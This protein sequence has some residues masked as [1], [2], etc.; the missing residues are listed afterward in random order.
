MSKPDGQQEP[1]PTPP[2]LVIKVVSTQGV[3][4]TRVPAT[5]A[6][7]GRVEQFAKDCAASASPV[8]QP[9]PEPRIRYL[10]DEGDWCELT[11]DTWLDAVQLAQDT[12][13]VLRVE[14]SAKPGT[15][16][17]RT[18]SAATTA[19][20][21]VST[22]P[23]TTSP[24]WASPGALPVVLPLKDTAPQGSISSHSATATV[25]PTA[26]GTE[27]RRSLA[28]SIATVD[29]QP[30][31]V[32][33]EAPSRVGSADPFPVWAPPGLQPQP[34]QQYNTPEERESNKNTTPTLGRGNEAAQSGM[35]YP[36]A[37][38]STRADLGPPPGFQ[39][40]RKSYAPKPI[41][42][43]YLALTECGRLTPRIMASV[44][45]NFIPLV[46]QR[47]SRHTDCLTFGMY[48]KYYRILPTMRAVLAAIQTI[49]S[50]QRF[51]PQLMAIVQLGPDVPEMCG[52]GQWA[53]NFLKALSQE[54]FDVEVKVLLAMAEP[55]SVVVRED[56]L[57]YRSMLEV[58][59]VHITHTGVKC[60]MCGE[61]PIIGPKFKCRSC[62]FNLCGE[63][64]PDKNSIHPEHDFVCVLWP[65]RDQQD[66]QE[67][68]PQQQQQ[69]AGQTPVAEATPN[70]PYSEFCPSRGP[71]S[72]SS[73]VPSFGGWLE[74]LRN[75]LTWPDEFRAHHQGRPWSHSSWLFAKGKGKGKGKGLFASTYN[76]Y[77]SWGDSM[78][79][80]E[81][82]G[83]QY[84]YNGPTE[85]H[86][87][88]LRHLDEAPG[89]PAA[90]VQAREEPRP[91]AHKTY[92]P[93]PLVKMFLNLNVLGMLTPRTLASVAVSFLPLTI[94]RLSRHTDRISKA[95]RAKYEW[96]KP[97]LETLLSSIEKLPEMEE[98]VPAL[99]SYV[100]EG[101]DS[102][103]M[104]SF[105]TWFVNSM[106]AFVAV[107]FEKQMPALLKVAPK[108]IRVITSLMGSQFDKHDIPVMSRAELSH[109]VGCDGCGVYP[110]VGPRFKCQDCGYDF[111]LCGECYPD[112]ESIHFKNHS[113]I[114]VLWPDTDLQTT[115][116]RLVQQTIVKAKDEA[117]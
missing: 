84:D 92:T 46:V 42:K 113:F 77:G 83:G 102:P 8:G 115:K 53:V 36:T 65:T 11:E 105:G 112:K 108:W 66:Q 48:H 5:A 114:C 63:C 76:P 61:M 54:P 14:L 6:S 28:T 45:A 47:I 39:Q 43:M 15:F 58:G 34:R 100:R 89:G 70:A 72:D 18:S 90:P 40:Q 35:T 32:G 73:S 106:K 71:S 2:N 24:T 82:G 117:I 19:V 25:E 21:S 4:R 52:M 3:W 56:I 87:P 75:S 93:K 91:R 30:V 60:N 7:F 79:A 67:A 17:A 23:V 109:N 50:L 99:R 80:G 9:A 97:T 107:P 29:S 26:T 41:L 62:N 74:M 57:K 49:P 13:G 86:C 1:T 78:G 96:I 98:F 94:Q 69:S 55:W 110:I 104:K 101:P 38:S 16:L 31:H 111:D 10:D 27:T 51:T 103:K 64:F 95:A 20:H 81:G 68:A 116:V 44:M 22:P 85:E 88:Y 59:E 37:P 12:K 33:P